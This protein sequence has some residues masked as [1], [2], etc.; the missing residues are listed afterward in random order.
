MTRSVPPR[1]SVVAK[2]V[3]EDVGLGVVVKAG[4]RGDAG[5]DV[6]GTPDAEP[7]AASLGSPG[8]GAVVS[9]S[10]PGQRHAGPGVAAGIV[11][12]T[13]RSRGFERASN[14]HG[15]RQVDHPG[16]RGRA[17]QLDTTHLIGRP[18]LPPDP[19]PGAGLGIGPARGSE[20]EGR[21]A[22]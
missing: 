2:R 4:R 18:C 17:S 19:P 7:S 13:H 9:A 3:P 14:G 5:D 1:T 22:L 15:N 11:L 20:P 12:G 6:V 21:R 10:A 8:R 16:Q